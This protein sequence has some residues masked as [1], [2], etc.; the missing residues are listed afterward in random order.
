MI[1]SF[2]NSYRAGSNLRKEPFKA[3]HGL[4]VEDVKDVVKAA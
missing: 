4:H 1:N 2:F 3:R